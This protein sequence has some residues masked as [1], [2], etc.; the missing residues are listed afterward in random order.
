MAGI[1]I[2][3]R[4][5]GEPYS[6]IAKH[7]PPHIATSPDVPLSSERIAFEAK[8][9][10]LFSSG[11]Q[12]ESVANK[13]VRPPKLFAFDL[14]R[15]LLL[16]E[17]V[18][19]FKELDRVDKQ[20]IVSSKTGETLGRLSEICIG[21]HSKMMT[22]EVHSIILTFKK[23]VTSCSMDRLMNMVSGMNHQLKRR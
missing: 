18:G 2:V 9:L 10:S 3:W 15:S 23:S 17:D 21:L 6:L 12:L 5:D 14:D 4:I 19:N 7:A 22:C 16:M 8:A 11:G 13:S 20:I 1:S